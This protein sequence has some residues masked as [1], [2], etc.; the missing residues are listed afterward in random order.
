MDLSSKTKYNCQTTK[1]IVRPAKSWIQIQKTV[2]ESR[3]QTC[4][5][6]LKISSLEDISPNTELIS[7][8]EFHVRKADMTN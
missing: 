2:F 5:S 3:N 6:L 8:G 4:S 1:M 7:E